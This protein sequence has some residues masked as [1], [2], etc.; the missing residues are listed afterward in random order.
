MILCLRRQNSW[1][2]CRRPFPETEFSSGLW[3]RSLTLQ[4][5]RLG[6]N[7]LFR[8]Y[9]NSRV[10]LLWWGDWC[11]CCVCRAG[12]TGACRGEDSSVAVLRETIQGP[13]RCR[14]APCFAEEQDVH[15]GQVAREGTSSK[16]QQAPAAQKKERRR[17][18][19]GERQK[20]KLR[21]EVSWS[22][23]TWRVGQK[24]R[25]TRG[26]WW[27]RFSSRWTDRRTNKLSH[28]STNVE[29][30]EETR[31]GSP[32]EL[33]RTGVENTGELEVMGGRRQ[34]SDRQRK[35]RSRPRERWEVSGGRDQGR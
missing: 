24:R 11:P 13:W 28:W 22:R 4:S 12:L 19:K 18:W 27:S 29:Q 10:A 1:W 6:R 30:I 5:R 16:R 8:R 21:K 20:G 23:R 33:M 3:R 31:A 25:G 2:K 32:D 17:R 9:R 14:W 7:S 35:F 34:R 15:R 26:R